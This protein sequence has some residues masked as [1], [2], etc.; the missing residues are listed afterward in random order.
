MRVVVVIIIIKK[1]NN[2]I[3]IILNSDGLKK[4]KVTIVSAI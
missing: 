1:N 4:I 2:N 3:N